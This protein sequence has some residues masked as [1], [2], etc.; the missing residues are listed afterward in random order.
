MDDSEAEAAAHPHILRVDGPRAGGRLD[1]FVADAF[2]AAGR[3]AVAR[4]IAA[5]G[6][7]VNGRRAVKGQALQVGDRVGLST[8]PGAVSASPDPA[9]QLR[10][11][12]EDPQ[13]VVVDK[14]PGQPSHPLR[15]GELATLAG[16]LLSRYPEMAQVGYH[17]R[18]PGLLHRLDTGTSGLLL[19]ARDAA[20]FESL[21]GD[22]SGGRIH[23]Q[24]LAV[25]AGRVPA[26][27]TLRGHL[28]AA[29]A[30]VRLSDAAVPGSRRVTL[31][32]LDSWPAQ[33]PDTSVVRLSAPL[34]GRHQIRVQLAAI[35]HPLLGDERY[36]GPK[37]PGLEHHLLHAASLA[38]DHPQSG[39]HI[40][41]S[42]GPPAAFVRFAGT[43]T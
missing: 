24:Y 25:C 14:P 15:P 23:K 19:C 1:R 17:A 22:L 11:V 8:E 33:Q 29:G 36:G 35:G 42:T 38:F 41:L 30:T 9:V 6:V 13:L 18:E 20:T 12:H 32:V 34:A 26:P 3:A 4:L 43:P 27:A 2:P 31:Q 10:V 5:G 28:I 39:A 16:G 37:R 7:V 40:S 21:R